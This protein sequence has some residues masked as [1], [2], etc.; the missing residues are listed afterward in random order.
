MLPIA[1]FIAI[2]SFTP[3]PPRPPRPPAKLPNPAT[4][5][6]AKL[7]YGKGESPA[8]TCKGPLL[9]IASA[10]IPHW[11]YLNPNREQTEAGPKNASA[12]PHAAPQWLLA[13]FV[14]SKQ[15]PTLAHP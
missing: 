7:G 14:E 5:A 8:V 1:I 12:T 13:A 2:F 11:N 10:D 15:G 9:S 4:V 3:P 6:D